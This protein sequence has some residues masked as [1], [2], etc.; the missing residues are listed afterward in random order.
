MTAFPGQPLC[1]MSSRIQVVPAGSQLK[2]RRSWDLFL[3]QGGGS[4]AAILVVNK[5]SPFTLDDAR[6]ALSLTAYEREARYSSSSKQTSRLLLV[7]TRAGVSPVAD[8]FLRRGQNNGN[9]TKGANMIMRWEDLQGLIRD[10]VLGHHIAT[11]SKRRDG[12]SGLPRAPTFALP[13][14]LLEER[15]KNAGTNALFDLQAPF[16]PS[17]DQPEA[18]EA[19]ARGL[20]EGKRHQTLLGATGTVSSAT[21]I[22]DAS[23]VLAVHRHFLLGSTKVSLS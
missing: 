17:G 3:D 11:S 15:E 6:V 18:I 2:R 12:G 10:G 21:C 19:L 4:E 5:K 1:C 16:E 8:A 9:S 7:A 22:D 14:W 13:S 23:K 20:E